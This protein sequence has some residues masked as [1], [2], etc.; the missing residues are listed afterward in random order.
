MQRDLKYSKKHF[1]LMK[2]QNM[3]VVIMSGASGSGK[4]T[5]I[6]KHY[7]SASIVSAD[8]FFYVN[9]E[10]KFDHNMLG[11]AHAQCFRNFIYFLLNN[12]NLIVVNN[13]NTSVIEL[14][15]YVA[16][17]NAFNATFELITLMKDPALCA[18]RNVHGVSFNTI[19][20]MVNRIKNRHIPK[21][22]NFTSITEITTD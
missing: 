10:Y 18:N 11:L 17:A 14:A 7:N 20:S 16:A 5:Y 9:G 1:A 8:D 3:H 19:E 21:H 6:E 4:N 15:P 22:W 13:T 12:H 2:E